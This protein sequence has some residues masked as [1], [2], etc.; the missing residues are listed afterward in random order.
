MIDLE[1][2]T[3][4]CRRRGLSWQLNFWDAD[5]SYCV[6]VRGSGSSERWE[7]KRNHDPAAA[8]RRVARKILE[9]PGYGP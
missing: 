9:P 8:F 1:A 2:F 7:D 6:T 5:N 4:F 3:A